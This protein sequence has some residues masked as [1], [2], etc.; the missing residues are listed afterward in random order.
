M[1]S[2][3]FDF[4]PPLPEESPWALLWDRCRMEVLTLALVALVV[5]G[6][7]SFLQAGGCS[8]KAAVSRTGEHPGF[9]ELPTPPQ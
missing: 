3:S 2:Q 6:G 4:P 7:L 5:V 1:S 8:P 9:S